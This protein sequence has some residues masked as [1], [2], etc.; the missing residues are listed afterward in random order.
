[1]ETTNTRTGIFSVSFGTKFA[2]AFEIMMVT[3]TC[4]VTVRPTEVVVKSENA[5][6]VETV[7]TDEVQMSHGVVDEVAAFAEAILTE[8]ADLDSR[9][10]PGEALADLEVLEAM[11]RSGEAGGLVENLA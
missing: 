3:D 8:W 9:I 6:G 4:C 2:D 7:N 1:M 10:S 5:V 11:L